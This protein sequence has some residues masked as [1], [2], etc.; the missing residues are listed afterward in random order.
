MHIYGKTS[1]IGN[2]TYEWLLTEKIDGSNLCFVKY[3]G[4]L[5]IMQRTLVVNANTKPDYNG[6]SNKLYTGLPEWLEDYGESLC[7]FLKDDMAICGEWMGMARKGYKDYFPL[8]NMF[9]FGR[10]YEDGYHRVVFN[11]DKLHY[12][13]EEFH[14]AFHDPHTD[15][16]SIPFFIQPV[17]VIARIHEAPT[18]PMLDSIYTD[19]TER[20]GRPVEGIV[21]TQKHLPGRRCKYVRMKNGKLKP[22]QTPEEL[23]RIREQHKE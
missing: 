11:E 4:A 17:P 23:Q 5:W 3:E 14:W 16:E 6:Y 22:H 21:I 7:D 20:V 9:G 15:S 19:Y 13:P 10:I 2:N 8:Y 18:V 1:R 12:D